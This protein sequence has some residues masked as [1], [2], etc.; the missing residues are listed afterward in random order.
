VDSVRVYV[1]DNSPFRDVYNNV[2]VCIVLT[3]TFPTVLH[4]RETRSR[5]WVVVGVLLA[6]WEECP[7]VV[8]VFIF[9]EFLFCGGA[10]PGAFEFD[11]TLLFGGVFP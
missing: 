8:F 7:L 11:R 3:G 9:P 4:L 6:Y 2:H 10:F 1:W 5:G